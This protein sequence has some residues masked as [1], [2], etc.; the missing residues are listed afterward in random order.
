MRSDAIV[1]TYEPD[2]AA[3]LR[4]VTTL[5]PQVGKITI[6]DNGS[7]NLSQWRERLPASQVELIAQ[8]VN[9][10]IALALNQ[11][12]AATHQRGT[13]E[14]AVLFDQDSTPSADMVDRLEHYYDEF[15]ARGPVAQVGPYFFEQ[16]RGQYL[17]FIEFKAGFPRRKHATGTR[18]WTTADYLITSGALVSLRTIAEVGPLDASLFIDYVDIEWGLR[19]KAA[20]FQSYGVFDVRMQHAIG[21]K[22]LN[23]GAVRIAMHRPVRR[24][25]YYRNAILLCRRRY[26]PISWKLHETTRLFVK[27]W[28]F[29]LFSRHRIADV[30]MMLRG[31]FDGLAGRTGKYGERGA[32][33]AP[34]Q[35]R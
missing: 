15:A 35:A 18:N 28:I 33:R 10:G 9:A 8:P 26:V 24:Y 11:G 16:N 34:G 3:L 31:T 4:L 17:P 20:G 25:Y 27:F 5:A 2:T 30:R 12:F 7:A 6:V 32:D 13:A 22:A 23:L 21:E 14:F 29:A 19:A 1:V